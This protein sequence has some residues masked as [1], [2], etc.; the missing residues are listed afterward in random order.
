[1]REVFP[2]PVN[3]K[4]VEKI[5][6]ICFRIRSEGAGGHDD[7]RVEDDRAHGDDKEI[8]TAASEDP[9]DVTA[10]QP[11]QQQGHGQQYRDLEPP[12]EHT[13]GSG[14]FQESS[15]ILA[16]GALINQCIRRRKHSLSG[17]FCHTGS[18]EADAPV[19][20]DIC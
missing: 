11:D 1:M 6:I 20:N 10:G 8:E 17:T 15:G 4:E 12:G 5:D 18:K 16:A 7:E 3:G 13:A 9:A 19:N 2:P 14:I